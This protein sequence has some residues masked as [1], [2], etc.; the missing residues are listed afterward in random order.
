[1]SNSQ[2]LTASFDEGVRAPNYFN[3]RLLAAEDLKADQYAVLARQGWLGKA[4]GYGV[5]EGLMVSYATSTS[6]QITQGI[7]INRQGQVMHLQNNPSLPLSIQSATSQT[8]DEAGRFKNC[9]F[10]VAGNNSSLGDGAYLLTVIPAS[11]LDGQAHMKAAAGST[12]PPRCA[13]QWPVAGLQFKIIR[14]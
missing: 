13:G 14:M 9:N 1:M 12:K 4:C 3:G 10:T 7:G 2:L 5:I 11:R 8:I 6:V